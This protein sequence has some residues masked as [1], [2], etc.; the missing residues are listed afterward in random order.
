ML[1]VISFDCSLN[2]LN[3]LFRCRSSCN[4]FM[5]G[6][7]SNWWISF[8]T[9]C[10]RMWSCLL[11]SRVEQCLDSEVHFTATSFPVRSTV[12]A[13]MI[14]GRSRV[15]ACSVLASIIQVR[16]QYNSLRC[17]R[18]LI[19][20]TVQFFSRPPDHHFSLHIAGKCVGKDD[21]VWS[22]C[23]PLLWAT[24]QLHPYTVFRCTF[25]LCLYTAILGC[26]MS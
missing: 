4:A 2:G 19:H 14:E 1:Y 25:Q 20:F 17:N 22:N 9:A 6:W 23:N 12:L 11:D 18:R 5:F 26:V 10:L 21:R 3:A 7:F 15:A 24:L 13:R 16:L 8:W